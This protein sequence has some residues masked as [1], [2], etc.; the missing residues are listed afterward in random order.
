[1]DHMF[2]DAVNIEVAVFSRGVPITINFKFYLQ[3]S[4]LFK[5]Y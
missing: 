2:K 5:L 4:H 3:V 1:M